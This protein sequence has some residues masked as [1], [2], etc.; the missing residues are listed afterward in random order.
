MQQN[1][2][3][4]LPRLVNNKEKLVQGAAKLEK[5]Y[6]LPK[7]VMYQKARSILLK[8]LSLASKGASDDYDFAL[9]DIIIEYMPHL[10]GKKETFFYAK[11]V[12]SYTYLDTYVSLCIP[13][14]RYDWFIKEAE[15]LT[16]RVIRRNSLFETNEYT[17]II[18]EIDQS[19]SVECYVYAAD[20]NDIKCVGH[21][22][23]KLTA[24]KS[25]VTGVGHFNV[26]A[27]QSRDLSISYLKFTLNRFQL[28]DKS[29][30]PKTS[31]P[32]VKIQPSAEVMKLLNKT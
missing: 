27:Y 6:F 23:Q 13:R 24:L 15:R 5:K 18:A 32:F 4:L 26:S 17:W 25:D 14:K 8:H 30:K 19:R 10:I 22:P 21:L 20:S 28:V 7:Q 11:T 16:G 3:T 9:E 31:M 12:Y 29:D 1:A 2:N